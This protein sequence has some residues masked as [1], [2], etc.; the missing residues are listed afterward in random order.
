MRAPDEKAPPGR[1]AGPE[2]EESEQ[3]GHLMSEARDLS[4][5]PDCFALPDLD[6]MQLPELLAEG[7]RLVDAI[8]VHGRVYPSAALNA[9]ACLRR[10][11]L[12]HSVTP[13][14][15]SDPDVPA[16]QAKRAMDEIAQARG[17]LWR[18]E[19]L[20]NAYRQPVLIQPEGDAPNAA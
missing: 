18:L 3:R 6:R 10:A 11:L 19:R 13:D 14:P 8:R 5:A 17:P 4:T 9:S 15:W 16:A 2:T 12:P 7:R 20:R 1:E